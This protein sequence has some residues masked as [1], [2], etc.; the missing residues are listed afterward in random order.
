M[1][2]IVDLVFACLQKGQP[3][4]RKSEGAKVNGAPPTLPIGP[5][6]AYEAGAYI[7]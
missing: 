1:G 7:N 2:K 5:G 3:A 4:P 6:P